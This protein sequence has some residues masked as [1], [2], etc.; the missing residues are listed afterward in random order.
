[1]QQEPGGQVVTLGASRKAIR[2]KKVKLEDYPN[3]HK[4]VAAKM[5][6]NNI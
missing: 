3:L 4:S 2:L 5:K 6:S 1:M